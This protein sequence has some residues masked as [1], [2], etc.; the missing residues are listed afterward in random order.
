VKRRLH[1]KNEGARTS[2]TATGIKK[3]TQN[4][5]ENQLNDSNKSYKDTENLDGDQSN[6]P[7]KCCEEMHI[8]AGNQSFDPCE[9]T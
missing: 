8:V 9:C 1:Q 7:N 2:K 5:E 3:E 4:V 6:D